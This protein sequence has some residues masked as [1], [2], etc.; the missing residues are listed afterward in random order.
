MSR[1][2]RTA[3]RFRR[4]RTEDAM[5]R[6]KIR[7]GDSSEGRGPSLFFIIALAIGLALVAWAF[8]VSVRSTPAAKPKPVKA[9]SIASE[10]IAA[11]A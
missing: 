3:R 10:A 6:R 5:G 11:N 1:T 2:F 9:T 4:R 8:V 7:K